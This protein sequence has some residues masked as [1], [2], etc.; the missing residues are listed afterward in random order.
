MIR[1][2]RERVGT[3]GLDTAVK[4]TARELDDGMSAR[5]QAQRETPCFHGVCG[6]P[7][8]ISTL[9]EF[10]LGHFVITQIRCWPVRL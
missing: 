8:V 10:Y 2:E 5:S 6:L 9:G 3:D 1:K 4:F 7:R